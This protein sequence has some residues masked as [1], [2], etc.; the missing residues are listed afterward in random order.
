MGDGFVFNKSCMRTARVVVEVATEKVVAVVSTA[1]EGSCMTRS[2]FFECTS[3]VFIVAA[4]AFWEEYLK[5]FAEEVVFRPFARL[6]EV[7]MLGGE[8]RSGRGSRVEL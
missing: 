7:D 6:E 5:R 4:T 8:M 2:R 3:S 1:E